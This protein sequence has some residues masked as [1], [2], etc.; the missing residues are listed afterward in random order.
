MRTG[1][2]VAAQASMLHPLLANRWSPARFDASH[3]IADD[4]VES[5]LEAARWAPSAGNSQPW[6][7]IAGRR[8]DRLHARLG[9]YLAGSSAAWAPTASLLVANLAHRYVEGT[10]WEYSE[11][12]SYDL[13]QAVAHMSL[14]AEALGLSARQFRAFN[15]DG[16]A[17]EFAV[18]PHWEV[19]TMTAIGRAARKPPPQSAGATADDPLRRRRA[20]SDIVWPDARA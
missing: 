1:V 4:E 13:G 19:T 7:F 17:A 5:L 20:V 6:A 16:I 10:D 11:F 15:R 14:Q 2:A 12:S 3:V 8:G 9:R 18:P